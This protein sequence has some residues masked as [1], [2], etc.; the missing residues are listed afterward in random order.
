MEGPVICF[1]C[2]LCGFSGRTGVHT[3]T[4]ANQM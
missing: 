2:V 1:V 4:E 3:N